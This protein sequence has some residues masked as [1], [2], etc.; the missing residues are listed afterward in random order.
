MI[1]NEETMSIHDIYKI[2]SDSKEVQIADYAT[3]SIDSGLTVL[4]EGIWK[5]RSDFKGQNIW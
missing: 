4:Q 2:R 5:R 1:G 3:W